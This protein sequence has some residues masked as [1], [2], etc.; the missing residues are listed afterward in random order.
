MHGSNELER[1]SAAEPEALG[2]T[3]SFVDTGEEERIL[4]GILATS[5]PRAARRGRMTPRRRAV[6]VLV[7][8]A[9]A[10][11]VVGLSSI[12][13]GSRRTSRSHGQQHH[14]ALS[15]ATIQLSGYHFKTPAGFKAST[16]SCVPSTSS[17]QVGANGFA[18]AASAAGGCVEAFFLISPSGE[19]PAPNGDP[20]TVGSRQ[21]YYVQPDS[22]G[23]SRLYVQLPQ[24][25]DQSV[26]LLLFSHGLT[27]D[28]LI[29]VANSGLPAAN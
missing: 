12:G 22:S 16:D 25:S 8:V 15:G 17:L 29:A 9:L 27:E 21:G 23:E 20:V 4:E 18:S 5:R 3:E 14:V 13:H 1:L 7:G 28:Q 19:D 10:A 26:Y 2:R 11:A 24:P 6:F